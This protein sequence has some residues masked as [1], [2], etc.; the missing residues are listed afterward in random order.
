MSTA[1]ETL[2]LPST[3][4]ADKTHR[5]IVDALEPHLVNHSIRGFLFARAH[6]NTQGLQPDQD[7]NEEN[8]F[9]ICALHDIGLSESANGNQQ[10]ELDGAD[11]AA[12]FLEDN[13]VTDERVDI[14]WDGI[15][16]HTNNFTDSPVY[17]RRRPAEIWIAAHGIGIDVGGSP[18]DLPPG[19]ADLTHRAY[20]R[21]GG[22]PALTRSVELQAL[23]NPL[24][25]PPCTLPGELV[26]QRH[27]ELPYATLEMLFGYNGWN[28]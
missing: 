26:H 11:F 12:C 23:A 2:A 6:A 25:A 10:F 27:P 17:R 22:T 7:Y 15:A 18:A 24:K 20:P 5:L 1:T 16:V 19:F 14:I 9:L 28:D 21:L 3:P 8:L 13:G 4:L